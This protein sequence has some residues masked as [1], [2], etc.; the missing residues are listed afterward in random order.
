MVGVDAAR[1]VLHDV[2]AAGERD[3]T[4]HAGRTA[5][6]QIGHR[7]G[8]NVTDREQGRGVVGPCRGREAEQGGDDR[9]QPDVTQVRPDID[10]ELHRPIVQCRQ[11]WCGRAER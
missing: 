5:G 8:D 11:P 1:I 3:H 9:K 6:L 4:A 10:P 2:V 7:Q